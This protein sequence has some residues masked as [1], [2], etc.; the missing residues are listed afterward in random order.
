MKW[1]FFICIV[2][3]FAV[4][5][6]VSLGSAKRESLTYDEIVHVEEGI[7][8]WKKR[9]FKVDTNNPPLVREFAVI[10]LLIRG[11]ST[12]RP[13]EHVFPSRVMIFMLFFFFII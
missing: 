1:V 11:N 4:Y 7:A 13:N 5:T 10:P 12:L 3:L 9:E 6:G 8:A 2:F